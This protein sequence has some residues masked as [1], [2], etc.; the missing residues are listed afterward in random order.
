MNLTKHIAALV[1]SIL[2]DVEEPF[3]AEIEET[4]ATA[5]G[6]LSNVLQ[7]AAGS[8]LTVDGNVSD[9]KVRPS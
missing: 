9:S 7:S 1:A 8:N 3:S 5:V 4:A 6:C 2:A